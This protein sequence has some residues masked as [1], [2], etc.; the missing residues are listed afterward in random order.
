MD[1]VLGG[2]V[3]G[4]MSTIGGGLL[5]TTAQ[6]YQNDKN[7]QFER[8]QA[9][10][11]RDWNEEMFN[12]SNAWNYEM[13]MKQN[14]YNTPENQLK[15][16]QDAGLNPMFYGL[17]GSSAQGIS[18]AQPLGYDRA[19]VG[20]QLNPI[21]AGLDTA[22]KIAQVSNIQ[23]N[24]AKQNNETQTETAKREKLLADIENTK[25]ELN[26]LKAQE[27]LTT[28]QKENLDKQIS[29]MDRMNEAI[30]SEKES[31]AKLNNSQK[32]RIDS[33]LEGEKILQSK[34]IK[35]FDKKWEKISKEIK[36]MSKETELLEKDIENYALNHMTNG[37][38]GSGA[39]IQNLF[40]LWGIKMPGEEKKPKYYDNM[41]VGGGSR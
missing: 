3:S 9:N 5:G 23:A 38:G 31:N 4:V 22:V 17:D 12:K 32:K 30:L 25:Q 20:N 21:S 40:R 8:E 14:E 18:S 1:P 24:T 33:L 28:S 19:S 35:D 36:K 26:N 15:R 37:V 2:I 41:G 13:W 27:G 16:L 29:W 34:N 39:S 11:Q 6:M 10:L 7:R